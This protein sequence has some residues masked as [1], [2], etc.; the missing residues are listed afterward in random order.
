MEIASLDGIGQRLV[1]EW[2]GSRELNAERVRNP[3]D[4][5]DH[6]E[7]RTLLVHR[8]AVVL[9][10]EAFEPGALSGEE[11]DVVVRFDRDL[12]GCRRFRR[13]YWLWFLQHGGGL[14]RGWR[15]ALDFLFLGLG[16]LR[17]RSGIVPR[18]P[19]LIE[20]QNEQ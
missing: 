9:Q 10:L 13:T 8:C 2:S 6:L 17:R 12:S 14:R 16:F 5:R 4:R 7:R 15:R 19:F 1:I 11:R 18:H 20:D 3:R